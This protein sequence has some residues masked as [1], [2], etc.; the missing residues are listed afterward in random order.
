[1]ACK[2]SE[3]KQADG[4]AREGAMAISFPCAEGQVVGEQQQPATRASAMGQCRAETHNVRESCP[5]YRL[6]GVVGVRGGR[7]ADNESL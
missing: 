3:A 6:R 5:S 1:M 2:T 7:A 4:R